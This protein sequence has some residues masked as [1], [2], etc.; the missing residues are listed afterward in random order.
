MFEFMKRKQKLM[1][2]V[3][4]LHPKRQAPATYQSFYLSCPELDAI[5][6][7]PPQFR[8]GATLVHPLRALQLLTIGIRL[9]RELGDR[10]GQRQMIRH[11]EHVV[12]V[13]HCI[14]I[15]NE[16]QR[17]GNANLGAGMPLRRIG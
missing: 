13:L 16:M 6:G 7:P 3:E 11:R 4:K 12:G 10:K 8:D 15:H 9:A 1:R 2:I 14:Y 5:A 17:L